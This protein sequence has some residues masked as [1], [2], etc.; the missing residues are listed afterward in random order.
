MAA[1]DRRRVHLALDFI[2]RLTGRAAGL[3][4]SAGALYQAL[5]TRESDD[6]ARPR[7]VRDERWDDRAGA[8]GGSH[9]VSPETVLK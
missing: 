5:N 6:G 3:G 4:V 8:A 7:G 2:D 9:C 1:C